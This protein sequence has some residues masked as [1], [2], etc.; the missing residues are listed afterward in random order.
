M[1]IPEYQDCRQ[2][3]RNLDKYKG[4]ASGNVDQEGIA[5]YC[6]PF[7]NQDIS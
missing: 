7:L 1:N 3:T 5:F 2:D 6:N 4:R